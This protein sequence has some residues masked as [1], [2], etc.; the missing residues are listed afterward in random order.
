MISSIPAAPRSIIASS[1]SRVNG[2]PLGGRLHL[3]EAAVRGHDDVHVRLRG[4]VLRVV[5]VEQRPA[6]DHADRDGGD[7]AAER[8]RE[9][10]AVECARGGDVRARDRSAARAAVGLDHVAV[11]PEGALAERLE[12]AH[13]PQR[14]SDQPLD[15]DRAAALLPLRRLAG[16]AL[17]RR[18]GQ[19]RVLGRH[20]APARAVEPA[21]HALLDHRRAEHARLPLRVEDGAVREL[22][23]VGDQIERAELVVVLPSVGPHAAAASRVAISTCS[24]SSIGS[25]R[26]RRPIARNAAVSPVVRKL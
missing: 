13:R 18:R 21:R 25:C 14:T 24:T 20:P 23:E 2:L 7:L 4:R 12:V 19:E 17:A 26:N 22:D 8:L 1:S 16:D 5:E 6:L 15:L 3:D 10:E 11:E 9:P